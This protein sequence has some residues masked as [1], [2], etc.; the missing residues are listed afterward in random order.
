MKSKL[1][2][3]SSLMLIGMMIF[4]LSCKKDS[5]NTNSL[6]VLPNQDIYANI[7]NTGYTNF[8][9]QAILA[10]GGNPLHNYDWSIESSP[11]PPSGVTIGPLTGV[12]NRI[13]NS[14][15]GLSVGKKTF[16]VKVSDGSSTATGTIT[17]NIT[18]YTPGPAAILQ[19]LS[20]GFQLKDGTA[21]Q[22]YGASLFVMGGTPPYSWKL[23]QT[24]AGSADLTAAGLTI[25]GTAGI[26]RGTILNSASGKTINFKVIVTDN[27]GETAVYS[28]VYTINVN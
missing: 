11:T 2:L 20:S 15:T 24:Y 18:G 9:A 5:G 10:D 6:R 28:P 4:I 13:G 3:I 22:T 17:L 21:N 1:L 23:N 14:S 8:N 25:D 12:V 19:Q 27:T 16:N 7:D 26:V